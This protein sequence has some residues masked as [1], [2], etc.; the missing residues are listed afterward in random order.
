[1]TLADAENR[2]VDLPK[3]MVNWF[4]INVGQC[5]HTLSVWDWN[6]FFPGE[7][8]CYWKIISLKP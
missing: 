5:Y 4:M 2:M 1:M 8:V 7:L 6:D 3:R